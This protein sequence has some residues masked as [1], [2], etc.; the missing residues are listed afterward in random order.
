[1]PPN[2]IAYLC[3]SA[4]A[5]LFPHGLLLGNA[6]MLE[7]RQRVIGGEAAAGAQKGRAQT[8]ACSEA[9][10]NVST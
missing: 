2:R 7:Q 3:L 8:C 10:V 4:H 6:E 1:M 5:L 9:V